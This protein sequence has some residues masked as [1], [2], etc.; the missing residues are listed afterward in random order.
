MS[1][2]MTAE[3]FS[4]AKNPANYRDRETEINE[5]VPIDIII[6]DDIAALEEQLTWPIMV[7]VNENITDNSASKKR[8]EK[9]KYLE[10]QLSENTIK[11]NQ[12]KKTI[13][14]KFLFFLLVEKN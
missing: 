1:V 6:T 7:S 4:I 10:K 2:Q 11:M 3:E 12:M 14:C 8:V 5:Q 13:K 9:R